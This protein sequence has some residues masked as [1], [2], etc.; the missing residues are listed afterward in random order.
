MVD[1]PLIVVTLIL[2]C[3]TNDFSDAKKSAQNKMEK[4]AIMSR[5]R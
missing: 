1:G 5:C 4:E 3:Q 2:L